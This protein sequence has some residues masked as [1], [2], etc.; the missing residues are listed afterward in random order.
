MYKL[1][2]KLLHRLAPPLSI[3]RQFLILAQRVPSTFLHNGPIFTFHRIVAAFYRYQ[4]TGALLGSTQNDSKKRSILLVSHSMSL[5]GAPLMLYT[6]AR[7]LQ[8]SGFE[9]AIFCSEDG[10]L[11]ELFKKAGIGVILALPLKPDTIDPAAIARIAG[12]YQVIIA[13]T[14]LSWQAVLL[15][16][17]YGK[18]AILWI[19]EAKLGI[20][21]SRIYPG[22][23]DGLAVADRVIFPVTAVA[24]LYV[25]HVS[26]VQTRVLPYGLALNDVQKID[27]QKTSKHKRNTDS[28]LRLVCIGSLEPRKGQDFLLQTLGNLPTSLLDTLELFLI[29]RPFNAE[30]VLRIQQQA[31]MLPHV[32]FVGAVDRQA[33]M[34][35]LRTADILVLPSRDEVLPVVLLEAMYH[36]RAIIATRVGGV[37][38]AIS[39]G[40]HGLLVE[41]DDE[42][43]LAA[44]LTKLCND[45]ELRQQLGRNAGV[46]FRERFTLDKMG[47]QFI[48]LI[49]E[50][51]QLRITESADESTESMESSKPRI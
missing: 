45:R 30:Y 27:T 44:A 25:K 36:E 20:E 26:L 9:I 29:G 18:P 12:S 42:P 23:L 3:R 33:V 8:S 19:H 28:R 6:L 43:A 22:I 50:V 2:Y 17:A 14:V 41:A 13:N 1:M 51:L 40:V 11:H 47:E 32:T 4:T 15:A 49:D 46:R 7:Y 34:A 35:Y 5:S 24:Q 37:A 31:R 16:K 10:P 21:F 38:E 39:D 48:A